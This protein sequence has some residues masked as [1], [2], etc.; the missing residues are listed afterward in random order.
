VADL[1]EILEQLQVWILGRPISSYTLRQRTPNCWNESS[2][3]VALQY[4]SIKFAIVLQKKIQS[5]LCRIK[6]D[7]QSCCMRHPVIFITWY[8]KKKSVTWSSQFQSLKLTDFLRHYNCVIP[9]KQ[10]GAPTV[11]SAVIWGSNELEDLWCH[12]CVI[13]SHCVKK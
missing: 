6:R 1:H 10:V 7:Y 2:K 8:L 13:V 3:G 5:F 11:P 4:G 12:K 9:V